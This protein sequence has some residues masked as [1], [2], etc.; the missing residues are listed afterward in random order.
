MKMGAVMVR[1]PQY[2]KIKVEEKKE[3][4]NEDREGESESEYQTQRWM[5]PLTTYAVLIHPFDLFL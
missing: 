3:V 4:E 1:C 5:N 2:A